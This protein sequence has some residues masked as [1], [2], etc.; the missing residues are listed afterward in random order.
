MNLFSPDRPLLANG[1]PTWLTRNIAISHFELRPLQNGNLEISIWLPLKDETFATM[2]FSKILEPVALHGILQNFIN[3][4]EATC[5]YLFQDE[6]E[7]PE[8]RRYITN[9]SDTDEPDIIAIK[10]QNKKKNQPR[11]LENIDF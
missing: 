2:R 1:K 9:R 3:D 6:P 8:F 10:P 11:I 5:E 7:T 4:P